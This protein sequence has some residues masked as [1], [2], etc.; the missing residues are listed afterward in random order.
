M[1]ACLINI[2]LPIPLFNQVKGIPDGERIKEC[3]GRNSAFVDPTRW[4]GPGAI[5]LFRW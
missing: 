5:K 2:S 3:V 4:N 1:L